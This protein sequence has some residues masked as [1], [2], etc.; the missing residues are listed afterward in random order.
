MNLSGYIDGNGLVSNRSVAPG[1]IRGSDNGP[2]FSSIALL[3]GAGMDTARI[4][5]AIA[6]CIDSE[7]ALHRTPNDMSEDAPDDHYGVLSLFAVLRLNPGL[8]LPLKYAIQ[9]VMLYLYL[10]SLDRGLLAS[11]LAPLVFIIIS[12]SNLGTDKNETSNRILTWTIC[13]A[14]KRR[15]ILTRLAAYIWERRQYRIYG[16]F[17]NLFAIYYET[18]HPFISAV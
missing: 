16:K 5:H 7:G 4:S 1:T 12:L 17:S 11:L 10:L 14:L 3:L 15:G 18:G 9:P 2:L 13:Q 8:K 6:H